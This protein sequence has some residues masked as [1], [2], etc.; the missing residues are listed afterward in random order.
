M[1][2]RAH[3]R[4][5]Q[6]GAP[7]IGDTSIRVDRVDRLDQLPAYGSVSAEVFE[8]DY[9]FTTSQLAEAI[10][11]PGRRSIA[12]MSLMTTDNRSALAGFTLTRRATS[13]DCT[14]AGHSPRIAVA[15]SIAPPSALARGT[16]SSLGA[17]Y[18]QVD[19]LPTSRP[20]LER[21]GF[22]WLTDTYPCEWESPK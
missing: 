21:L 3:L 7:W 14:A 12:R 13:R 16:R 9:S 5:L 1:R 8:K 15:G 4:P 20:V 18:L 19:A 22:Q 6:S 11:A 2:S 10:S 17:R